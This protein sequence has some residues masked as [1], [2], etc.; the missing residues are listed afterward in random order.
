MNTIDMIKQAGWIIDLGPGG[1][2]K[3]GEIMFAGTPYDF[4]TKSNSL[5]AQYIRKDFQQRDEH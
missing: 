1:G 3:G 2:K 5:T 4:T